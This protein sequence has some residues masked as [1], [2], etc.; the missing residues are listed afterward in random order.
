MASQV[1]QF[2]GLSD[3]DRKTVTPLP[4]LAEGDH[5]ELLVA[6]QGG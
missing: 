3:R 6:A 5:V 2:A 4:T 1:V